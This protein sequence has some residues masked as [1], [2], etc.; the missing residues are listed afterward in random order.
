MCRCRC[1]LRNHKYVV[2]QTIPGPKVADVPMAV[3]DSCTDIPRHVDATK[4]KMGGGFRQSV[5]RHLLA[6]ECTTL[7]QQRHDKHTQADG[8]TKTKK[9]KK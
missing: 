3:D 6:H 1:R 7:T 4:I 9:K 8:F 5:E 2:Y